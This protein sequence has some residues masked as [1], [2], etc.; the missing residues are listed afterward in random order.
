MPTSDVEHRT[1]SRPDCPNCGGED[2]YLRRPDLNRYTCPDCEMIF[3]VGRNRVVIVGP[4]P[5]YRA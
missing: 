1:P 2:A 5:I 3:G 4:D